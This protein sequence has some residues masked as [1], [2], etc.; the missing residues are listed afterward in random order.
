MAQDLV[1][2]SQALDHVKVYSFIQLTK[3]AIH[4]HS[5]T[6][7]CVQA[8]RPC[9]APKFEKQLTEFGNELLR[10]VRLPTLHLVTTK[11]RLTPS[12]QVLRE[13]R[14]HHALLGGIDLRKPGAS[15]APSCGVVRGAAVNPRS[16]YNPAVLQPQ[17]DLRRGGAA[18]ASAGAMGVTQSFTT[19]GRPQAIVQESAM[20]RPMGADTAGS[21][22]PAFSQSERERP[23]RG[24]AAAA[25]PSA[26]W[27]PGY[28]RGAAKTTAQRRGSAPIVRRVMSSSV[29]TSG[30]ER[31]S[32]NVYVATS[33]HV[34]PST[35]SSLVAHTH[36]LKQ[37]QEAH[38]AA[39]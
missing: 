30:V 12:P 18:A 35:G 19:R 4:P 2:Y 24:T 15:L 5:P 7:E 34:M 38:G 16:N 9:V 1:P 11:G 10:E 37:A 33:G 29:S 21:S 31:R 36:T 25:D 20:L 32:S 6:R 26:S 14:V 27:Q 23:S 39:P 22:L 17:P 3:T 28:V 13:Y 8:I